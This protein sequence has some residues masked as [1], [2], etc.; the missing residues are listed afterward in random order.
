MGEQSGQIA[1]VESFS[2]NRSPRFAA[3]YER[4]GRACAKPA[5]LALSPPPLTAVTAAPE[6]QFNADMVEQS[7][8]ARA[9]APRGNQNALR[10]GL[11]TREA[12]EERRRAR[13]SP[14]RAPNC[15]IATVSPPRMIR[16]RAGVP[17]FE[18]FHVLR[19]LM[20]VDIT[21]WTIRL[22]TVLEGEKADFHQAHPIEVADPQRGEFH[23]R[24]LIEIVDGAER[25]IEPVKFAI[26]ADGPDFDGLRLFTGIIIVGE[27]N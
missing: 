13:Q 3:C 9:G 17:T 23:I 26:C 10:H 4:A 25:P 11:F 6:L 22:V 8:N 14:D 7:T 21:G 1:L 18:T 19:H 15:S 16:C 27:G 20:P 5:L 12:L 2:T 24:I